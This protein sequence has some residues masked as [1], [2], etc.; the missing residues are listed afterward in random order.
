VECGRKEQ[1]RLDEE[2]WRDYGP[3]R[4]QIIIEGGEGHMEKNKEEMME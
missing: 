1:R 2:E 3:K 4:D